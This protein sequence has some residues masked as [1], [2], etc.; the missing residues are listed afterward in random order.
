[1]VGQVAEKPPI[2]TP[3]AQLVGPLMDH[4]ARR[5]RAESES[6]LERS[7]LRARHVIALTLLRDLGDR[8]QAELA[9]LLNMD[10]TNVVG[11]LNDLESAG[12]VQRQ[13]SAEDRRR[14][15]VALTDAGRERLT[16]LEKT[17]EG[18][19]RRVLDALDDEQH[20][21]L[22]ALLQAAA[23]SAAAQCCGE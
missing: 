3:S 15:T 4:L 5:L 6:E 17:L 22:H 20:A 7:D 19:E 13:R 18:V 10:P 16:T 2:V 14:H 21:T 23:G 1:M 11:L 9:G 12:L 8:P